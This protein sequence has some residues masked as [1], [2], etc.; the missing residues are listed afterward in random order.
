[1]K[2]W[3]YTSYYC[4]LVH[5]KREF[6]LNINKIIELRK[7]KNWSRYKLSQVSDIPDSTLRDLEKAITDN[8][9]IK[10]VIAIAK[11]LNVDV[12]EIIWDI[13]LKTELKIIITRQSCLVKRYC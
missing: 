13:N 6:D 1:M 4:G 8:P 10:T 9:R 3:H 2:M 7:K 5:Q 11:A 12:N